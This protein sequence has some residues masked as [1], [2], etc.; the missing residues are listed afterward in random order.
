M[1]EHWCVA[2]DILSSITVN[3]AEQPLY[4][5]TQEIIDAQY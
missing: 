4:V 5:V 1:E 2:E 3:G